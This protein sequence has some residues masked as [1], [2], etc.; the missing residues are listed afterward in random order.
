MTGLTW[1]S[2]LS[3]T[4]VSPAVVYVGSTGVAFGAK[5]PSQSYHLLAMQPWANY[6]TSLSLRD[7][8]CKREFIILIL[9]ISCED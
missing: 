5:N 9:N 2:Q 7:H 3:K 4:Q 8:V 1:G 6:L